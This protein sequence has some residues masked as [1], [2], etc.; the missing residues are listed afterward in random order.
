[1]ALAFILAII[2][3]FAI[4][5]FLFSK[6]N[7]RFNLVYIEVYEDEDTDMFN[8][9]AVLLLEGIISS[10]IVIILFNLFIF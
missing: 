2:V 1:M 5:H 7:Q 3:V 4:I 10:L 8:R 9:D 6:L